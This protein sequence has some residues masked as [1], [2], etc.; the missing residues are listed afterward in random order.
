MEQ[1]ARLITSY[2]PVRASLRVADSAQPGTADV[3]GDLAI[4]I[5]STRQRA[6]ERRIGNTDMLGIAID[7][8]NAFRRLGETTFATSALSAK[9]ISEVSARIPDLERG[10]GRALLIRLERSVREATRAPEVVQ[11]LRS[12][13]LTAARCGEEFST[14]QPIVVEPERLRGIADRWCELT[15]LA[16]ACGAEGV[17]A[18][19]LVETATKVFEL[20]ESLPETLAVTVKARLSQSIDDALEK[21]FGPVTASVETLERLAGEALSLFD[22]DDRVTAPAQAVLEALEAAT[23]GVLPAR[24]ALKTSAGNNRRESLSSFERAIRD[25]EARMHKAVAVRPDL[26]EARL[27]LGRA[28]IMDSLRHVN[29]L[30]AQSRDHDVHHPLSREFLEAVRAAKKQAKTEWPVLTGLLDIFGDNIG[31]P[32]AKLREI[33]SLC[34]ALIASVGATR[35]ANTVDEFEADFVVSVSEVVDF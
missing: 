22:A 18:A 21:V 8:L 30:W 4:R 10:V 5:V 3:A 27:E 13:E 28:R 17:T 33:G 26:L 32:R 34:F 12:F 19:S 6:L 1:A 24:N 20:V 23:L 7:E 15:P 14:K 16:A 9:I 11:A 35:A 31:R 25:I 29:D 2:L